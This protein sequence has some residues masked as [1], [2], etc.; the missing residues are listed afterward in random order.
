MDVH[1]ARSRTTQSVKLSEARDMVAAFKYM[2]SKGF[3]KGGLECD[4]VK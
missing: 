2:D 3:Y 4:M 1:P